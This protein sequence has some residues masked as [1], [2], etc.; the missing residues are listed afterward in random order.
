MRQASK[1][2]RRSGIFAEPHVGIIQRKRR[3]ALCWRAFAVRSALLSFY[4][5]VA[6][7]LRE[8]LAGAISAESG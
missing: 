4:R 7:L 3:S 8:A 1:R 2:I 6:Y 5:V